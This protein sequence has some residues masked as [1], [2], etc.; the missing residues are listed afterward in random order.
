MASG[1]ILLEILGCY[2]NFGE[3]NPSFSPLKCIISLKSTKRTFYF[4]FKITVFF[5]LPS[6]LIL[7]TLPSSP[8]LSGNLLGSLYHTGELIDKS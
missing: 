1:L 4:L 7:M 8:Y 2:K 5:I 6:S 3:T